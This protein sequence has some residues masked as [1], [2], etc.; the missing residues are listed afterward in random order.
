M[1]ILRGGAQMKRKIYFVSAL[2]GL[3]GCT[4]LSVY[5][6]PASQP[7]PKMLPA[8][9]VYHLPAATVTPLAYLTISDCVA[10]KTAAKGLASP[11]R[12]A[13]GSVVDG[14]TPVTEIK[15]GVGADLSV[16]QLPDRA[17]VI[18]YRKLKTFLKTSSISRETYPSGML[19][20]INA[21]IEDQSPEAIADVAAV[22]GTVALIA[23]GAAPAVGIAAAVAAPI[24]TGGAGV[25]PGRHALPPPPEPTE[26]VKFVTCTTDTLK[27]IKAR[28]A[29][30][31]ERKKATDD[32]ND[33]S[34]QITALGET[35]TGDAAQK[36]L[37]K[38]K[39]QAATLTSKI[40]AATDTITTL[41]AGLTLP[42]E[43]IT[44]KDAKGT[45]IR[46]VD[47]EGRV[48]PS[49]LLGE[50]AYDPLAARLD[51]F[52][53]AY[54]VD[55]EAKMTKTNAAK[56]NARPCLK[57]TGEPKTESCRSVESVGKTI[58]LLDHITSSGRP[59]VAPADLGSHAPVG[60]VSATDSRT[61][62]PKGYVAASEGI[63]YIDPLK[64]RVTFRANLIGDEA[65]IHPT[66]VVKSVT[67][68]IPQLGRY[69]SLPLEAGFGE[70]V[71]LAA[72]FAEDGTLLTASYGNPKTMGKS[73]SGTLKS[74]SDQALT[75]SNA[76][77]DRKVKLTKDRADILTAQVSALTSSRTLNPSLDQVADLNAQLATVTAQAAIAQAQLQIK[78]ATAGMGTP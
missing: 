74:L 48:L 6:P 39:A 42:L 47:D 27:M 51:A 17:I 63:I 43:A 55:V 70:K 57:G 23:T 22:A 25:G 24:V 36:G 28:D 53:K 50:V 29:A 33:V 2:L 12:D 9:F 30:T 3:C 66:K 72:T 52:I 65:L 8:G 44:Q 10:D 1:L 68:S 75:T 5:E 58:A 60:L 61:A 62:F 15:F 40:N 32:L 13:K 21:S 71:T 7:A 77:E 14:A 19:K 69:L 59:F 18:D 46:V 34:A 78:T 38:L 16:E 73:I 56:F 31:A 49:A 64:T 20:S 11:A 54:F 45:V 26:T 4:S 76:M 41:T 37:A 35:G 67:V